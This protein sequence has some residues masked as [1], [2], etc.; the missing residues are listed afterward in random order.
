MEPRLATFANSSP[1]E[2]QYAPI[3]IFNCLYPED[4][5]LMILHDKVCFVNYKSDLFLFPLPFLYH[6]ADFP[7]G[8]LFRHILT[9]II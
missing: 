7:L 5:G 8:I 6:P 3:F 1:V 9:L 2:I 4:P